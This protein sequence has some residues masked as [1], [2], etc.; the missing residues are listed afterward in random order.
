MFGSRGVQMTNPTVTIQ[1]SETLFRQLE[2]LSALTGRPLDQLVEQTLRSG[3]PPLPDNLPPAA[4]D[5]LQMIENLDD[6]TLA[7]IV[8]ERHASTWVDQY[9]ELRERQRANVITPTEQQTLEAMAEEAD[10]LTVRKAYA[11][12]L[13]KWRGQPVPRLVSL[14]ADL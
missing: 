13:L 9:E 7:A 8:H 1:V 3:L 6:Q 12:V 4:R 11:A 5:A 14:E 2:R 10:L